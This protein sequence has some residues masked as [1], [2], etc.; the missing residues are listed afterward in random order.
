[1]GKMR[2]KG[3]SLVFLANKYALSLY[4]STDL[5]FTNIALSCG[6]VNMAV[7]SGKNAQN[8]DMKNNNPACIHIYI[9]SKY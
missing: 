9:A 1:M 6:N 3:R 8:T 7:N 2:S 4:M 5:S